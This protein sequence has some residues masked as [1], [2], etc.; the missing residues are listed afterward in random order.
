MHLFA[1][2]LRALANSTRA[3]GR[4]SLVARLLPP[5][6]LALMHWLLGGLLLQHRELLRLLHEGG[7]PMRYLFA[8]ALA[9]GPVVASWIGFAHA[10][11]Q[12]FE[13]PELELWL[14]AP[15]ARG[16]GAVQVLLR[17][18]GLALL[19]T[20]ALS[21]PLLVQ[22]LRAAHAPP[23]AYLAALVALPAVVLPP[24]CGVIAAQIAMMRLARGRLSRALLGAT[25][26]LAAFGFP[27]FLLAQVFGGGTDSARD[28]AAAAGDGER[29]HRLTAFA[30]DFVRGCAD[31][32]A[33]PADLLP[34]LLPAAAALVLVLLL[35]PLHPTAVQNHRLARSGKPGRR[36]RW[37]VSPLAVIRRK[38]LA[39]LLQQPGAMLHM[40]LVGAMV[41]VFAAQGTFVRELFQ[42]GGLPA[43]VQQCAAMLTL[44]FVAVLMLLYT[45]MGRLAA[46]DGAQW[47]LYL[48]SP[49]APTTLLAG[50]LQVI[51]ALLLWPLL[52]AGW[53]GAQWLGAGSAALLRF[54]PLALAGSLVALAVVAAVGTWPWLV[55]AEV[56]GRLNQGSRG[57][58]GS[59][60]LV[61]A[62]YFAL[63]PG[64]V[65]WMLLLGHTSGHSAAATAAMVDE[66]WP[67][68]VL[69]ALGFGG[70]LLAAA[71]GLSARNYR[72]LLR[73]R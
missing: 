40:I 16:R 62:F 44:W 23:I 42:T 53:A 13:A 50:K 1:A 38:E 64:L 7:D 8:H 27:V 2:D 70:V 21:L 49:V 22:L 31:G 65:A 68:I 47:P 41:H 61:F 10:Q 5:A 67:S 32:T 19:W 4:A 3:D 29:G 34:V 15:I 48:Q 69:G 35:A 36:A 52:V 57:L 33:G 6:L 63:A 56:D 55:R 72:R 66:L 30:A 43:H 18:A 58:V 46:A 11:R 39:Q 14:A 71:V 60:V 45:H 20:A 17:A 37:P 54:A 25:A 24:L 59:L 9:S 51:G 12:L 73:P 28:L 26:A